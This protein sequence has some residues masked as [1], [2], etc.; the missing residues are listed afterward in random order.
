MSLVSRPDI[1]TYLGHSNVSQVQLDRQGQREGITASVDRMTLTV[2]GVEV[3][4]GAGGNDDFSWN[5]DGLVTMKLGGIAVSAGNYSGCRLVVYASG[6]P[7]GEV[8]LEAEVAVK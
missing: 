2:N 8:W 6:D 7:D 4:S 1:V 5:D 3:D